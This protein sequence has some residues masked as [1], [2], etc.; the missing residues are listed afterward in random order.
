MGGNWTCNPGGVDCDQSG[1]WN[2][3]RQ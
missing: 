1:I 2:A 3:A